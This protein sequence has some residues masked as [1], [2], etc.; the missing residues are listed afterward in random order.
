M[1]KKSKSAIIAG[2]SLILMLIGASYAYGYVHGALIVSNNP[3]DT[4]TNILESRSLFLTGVMGWGLVILTDV[5]VTFAFYYYLRDVNKGLS[6]AA[7]VTRFIYTGVLAISVFK[8]FEIYQ[9]LGTKTLLTNEL[10]N[11]V[12]SKINFFEGTWSAGLILFGVHLVLIGITSLKSTSIPKYIGIL[13]VIAGCGYL[14][15][16][17]MDTFFSQH[18]SVTKLLES[19]LSLPMMI[20]ELG[21]GIWL[22]IKGRKVVD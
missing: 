19:I 4:L 5:L 10:A 14:L 22:L 20:G 16:N 17:G 11:E 21:F 12:M 2:V 6:L 9:L 15:V 7:A 18:D 1:N 8:L 3:I 13:L